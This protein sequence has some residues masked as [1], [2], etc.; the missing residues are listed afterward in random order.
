[1]MPRGVP[2]NIVCGWVVGHRRRSYRTARDSAGHVEC[3]AAGL[4]AISAS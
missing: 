4:R 2:R 3:D 1:M